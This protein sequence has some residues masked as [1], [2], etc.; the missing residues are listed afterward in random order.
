MTLTQPV[1]S[2]RPH[3]THP[4]PAL[5]EDAVRELVTGCALVP[6]GTGLVGLELERHVVDAAAPAR[7]VPWDRLTGLVAGFTPPAGS[8]LTLEPGG[9]VE[10][11][12]PPADL[13]TAVRTLELDAT[14]VEQLLASDGL[15][16]NSC[17]LD[18]LRAPQRVNPASRYRAMGEHFDAVGHHDDGA[19]MMCST[20]S[21][22]LNLDA[23][24]AAGWADRLAH[25]ARLRPLLVAMAATS[26]L[27][28]GIATGSACGRQGVWQ[29][30]E[31]GRCRGPA[32]GGDP[33]A[34]WAEFALDAPVMFVRADRTGEFDAVRGAV[35]LRDWAG[36]RVRLDGRGPRWADVEAHLTTLW[37]PV[38]LRGFLELRFLDAVPRRFRPGLVALVATAVD[39]PQARDLAAQAAEPVCGADV[40]AVRDGLADPAL[41]RAAGELLDAVAARVPAPLRGA[42]EPWYELLGSGRS[43]AGLVLDRCATS[44]PAGCLLA[45]DLR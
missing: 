3:E 44:G 32:G 10:L 34:R 23:G 45:E 40:V 28:Q 36:G 20:A 16:L 31:P 12:G 11:S 2:T 21:L 1:A 7:R 43:L 4:G 13:V 38:R 26:P 14:A 15:V 33:A 30:L 6:S 29:R 8:R 17:G 27:A 18:P 41:R 9:Q 5:D 22:Q 19:A 42:L 35:P 39:D 25:V 37:P 24:P